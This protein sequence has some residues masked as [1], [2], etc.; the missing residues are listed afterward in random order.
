MIGKQ[1][2]TLLYDRARK[3]LNSRNII[4]GWSKTGLPPFN[5]ERVL[6]DIQKP[7]INVDP[8]ATEIEKP[9]DFLQLQLGTPKTAENLMFLRKRIEESIAQGGEI[10]G[11]CKTYIQKLASAA[12]NAFAD[13]AIL[14]G[15]NLLLFEQNNEKATRKS[16]SSRKRESHELRGHC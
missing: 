8:I 7:G 1:H 2:F 15:E 16:N 3:A 13:R 4:S 11:P 9:C 5:P 14:L 10:S 6:K 12:E